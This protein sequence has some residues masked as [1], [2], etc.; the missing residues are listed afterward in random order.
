MQNVIVARNSKTGLYYNGTNFSAEF[1]G[2]KR[3][4]NEAGVRAVIR[5]AF[6]NVEFAKPY[7]EYLEEHVTHVELNGGAL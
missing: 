3:L 5:G 4:P 1:T 2:A 6:D 7:L